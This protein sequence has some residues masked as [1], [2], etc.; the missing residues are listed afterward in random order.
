MAATRDLEE[1]VRFYSEVFGLRFDPDT[2][3][4]VL[5]EWGSDS[6]FLLTVENWLESA[7]PSAFGLLV[8]DVDARHA[9]A[10]E[11]GATEVAG[12]AN[13]SWKP[14]CSTIDDPSGNRIQIAQA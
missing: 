2:S 11:H 7:T 8:D 3:S 9:L 10:L 14:R 1:S 4:F 6:F 13:H 12:P 5:G